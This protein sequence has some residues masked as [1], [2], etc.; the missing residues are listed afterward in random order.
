MSR[1]FVSDNG[2]A[3]QLQTGGGSDDAVRS[4]YEQSGPRSARILEST[5][6]VG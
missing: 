6:M 1:W 5:L 4:W 3:G 2:S